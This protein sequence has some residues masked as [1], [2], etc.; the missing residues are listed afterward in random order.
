MSPPLQSRQKATSTI[1]SSPE[2]RRVC[3]DQTHGL[4]LRPE[5]VQHCVRRRSPGVVDCHDTVQ[6]MRESH[7]AM[8]EILATR[9]AQAHAVNPKHL[10]WLSGAGFTLTS[11]HIA[12]CARMDA[13]IQDHLRWVRL[14]QSVVTLAYLC[15]AQLALIVP[16]RMRRPVPLGCWLC[17]PLHSECAARASERTGLARN[18]GQ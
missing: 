5:A 6:C 17:I 2:T 1:S 13:A 16:D 8:Q 18:T 9:P 15:A 7:S 10:W 4:Q 14:R 3:R 11:A 12:G